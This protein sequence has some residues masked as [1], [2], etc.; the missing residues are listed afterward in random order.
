MNS[1]TRQKIGAGEFFYET[2]ENACNAA[3]PV[4][5]PILAW[6]VELGNERLIPLDWPRNH[7]WKEED[8]REV[9]AKRASFDLSLIPIRGV[10]D[11]LE[12]E[13]RNAQR[14]KLPGPKPWIV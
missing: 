6:I 2:G 9:V 11:E 3:I 12:S 7:R 14:E 8:E 4:E 10:V 5:C 1:Y 13:K